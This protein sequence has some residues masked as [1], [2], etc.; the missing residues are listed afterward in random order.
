M[1][2]NRRFDATKLPGR[3]LNY[4]DPHRA[5]RGSAQIIPQTVTVEQTLLPQVGGASLVALTR[6]RWHVLCIDIYFRAN[7]LPGEFGFASL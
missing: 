3:R 4:I 1:P 5:S 6:F 7:E 2:D